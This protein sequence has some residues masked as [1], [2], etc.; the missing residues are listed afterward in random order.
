[1]LC[2]CFPLVI[3]FTFGSVYMS[4]PLSHFLPAY[5]SPSLYP[6]VHSLVGQRLYS[7]LAP[8][9]FMTFFFFFF[10]RFHIY[11]TQVL[12]MC[13]ILDPEPVCYHKNDSEVL[14]MSSHQIHY[15]IHSFVSFTFNFFSISIYSPSS[16][17]S[18]NQHLSNVDKCQCLLVPGPL[19][20]HDLWKG[21]AGTYTG[22]SAC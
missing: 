20:S 2:G 15:L 8:R 1:M 19:G 18:F 13:P 14:S 21:Q 6:Q 3:Y 16:F 4:I 11:A 17:Q 22:N 5:P 7:R 12:S 9:F 10:F